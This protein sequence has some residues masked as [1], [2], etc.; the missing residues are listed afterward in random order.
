M[1]LKMKKNK[2]KYSVILIATLLSLNTYAQSNTSKIRKLVSEMQIALDKN[3]EEKVEDIYD[4]N[5]DDLSKQ[6]EA[7]EKLALSFERREKY[8]EASKIYKKLVTQAYP[9]EHA[10]VMRQKDLEKIDPSVYQKTNLPFYYYKLAFL[11]IQQYRATNE[12]TSK[13]DR[14]KLFQLAETSIV[15]ANKV[16]QNENEIKILRDLL[17]EKQQEEIDL[18]YNHS[19]YAVA[20]LTSWQDHVYLYNVSN[21][22]KTRLLTTN[23]GLCAGGGAKWEN[24]RYEFNMEGCLFRGSST[25]S[26][27]AAVTTYEQS[28]VPVTA[29]FMG[30]GM[31]LKSW[32]ESIKVGVQL[33]LFY[34]TGSWSLPEGNFAFGKKTLIGGGPVFQMKVKAKK[35][36]FITKFGKLFPNPSVVW[37][38]GAS[39][40][41]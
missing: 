10:E 36:N 19:W 4:E 26:S 30:P 13:A 21:S 27:E 11:F 2:N 5:E 29:L 9:R 28:S 23:I 18:T 16:S 40:D 32:S 35:V 7:L 33:P 22:S 25:I 12:Y 17:N 14:Q 37:S 6:K 1:V 20:F 41:F 15:F 24:I 8:L 31:Y 3:Q 38:L 39:Y 34:R